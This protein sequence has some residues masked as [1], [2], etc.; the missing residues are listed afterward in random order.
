MSGVIFEH[1]KGLL[2]CLST[3]DSLGLGRYDS[4]LGSFK[5]L[6]PYSQ[7]DPRV[8]YKNWAH[9]PE[10]NYKRRKFVENESKGITRTVFMYCFI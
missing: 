3:W 1:H 4:L 9:I 10:I 8:N 6:P 7:Q 5:T 2:A